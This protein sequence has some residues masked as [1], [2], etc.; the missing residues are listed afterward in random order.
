[1]KKFDNAYK[2]IGEV[3]DILDLKDPKTGKLNTHTI[4]YWETQFKQIKP[5][6][7]SSNRRYYD[8]NTVKLFIKIKYLLKE[9]GL[10]IEGVKRILSR[11]K[12]LKL[13]DLN[14]RFINNRET[15][16]ILK[17]NNISKIVK[18]LKKI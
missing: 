16:L 6:F 10:K 15:D 5:K 12:T 7:F 17:L 14:N 13:D 1:M 11:N 18:D 9:E 8:N 2:S 4:R 3:A